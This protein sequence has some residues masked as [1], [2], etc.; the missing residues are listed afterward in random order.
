MTM[1]TRFRIQVPRRCTVPEKIARYLITQQSV[2]KAIHGFML[3]ALYYLIAILRNRVGIVVD[4]PL[5]RHQFVQLHQA[6]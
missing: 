5:R 1:R 3:H 6:T 2:E 4:M